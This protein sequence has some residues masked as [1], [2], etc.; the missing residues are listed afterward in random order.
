MNIPA[1]KQKG[2][3]LLK[4]PV[5]LDMVI[6]LCHSRQTPGHHKDLRGRPRSPEI[7]RQNR[8]GASSGLSSP[9]RGM[10]Q[11]PSSPHLL[12]QL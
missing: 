11:I 9:T 1:F 4:S 2:G 10:K 5:G 8:E 6:A 3:N 12:P 7:G